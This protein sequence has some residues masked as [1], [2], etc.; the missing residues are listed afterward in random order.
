MNPKERD[1]KWMK[2][3][4]EEAQKAMDTGEHPFG[5]IIVAGNKE[6]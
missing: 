3:A 2:I 5:A 1:I 4:L 6:L